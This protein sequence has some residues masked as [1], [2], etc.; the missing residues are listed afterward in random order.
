L[1][2]TVV[3]FTADALPMAAPP[4]AVHVPAVATLKEPRVCDPWKL[5]YA[6]SVMLA[7]PPP[8]APEAR[9]LLVHD[10]SP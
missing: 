3:G 8:H 4:V 2:H 10:E 6:P 1:Q 7:Q 9:M 5:G